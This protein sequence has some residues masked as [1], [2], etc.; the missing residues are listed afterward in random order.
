M[1]IHISVDMEGVAGVADGADTTL[2]AAH[3]EYCRGL[4]TSECNAAIEGAFEAGATEVVVNDSHGTGLNLLQDQLDRRARVVRGRRKAYGMMQA[5]D[6]ETTATLFVGYHA[7][8][9]HDDGVLN[10]TMRG[11]DVQGVFLNDEFAGELRLN[12][13]LAGWHGVPVAV[14]SGDDVLCREGRDCLGAVEAVEVKQAIDKYTALSLHPR[15]AQDQIREATRRALGRLSD[16]RP[17][18]V[19][20]PTVLRVCWNSTSIASLCDNVPGVKRV[21]SREV[22]YTSGDYPELYRLL[23]LLLSLATSYAATPHTYD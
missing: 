2:G 6:S 15:E 22:E 10:H 8:A 4:M 12:A 23:R 18:Q 13:A 3:Y 20:S 21:G 11:A 1:K 19:D 5:I 14:I 17:Y 7:A 16:F 9:G